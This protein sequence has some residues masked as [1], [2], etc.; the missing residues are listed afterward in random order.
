MAARGHGSRCARILLAFLLAPVLPAARYSSTAFRRRA[1]VHHG[2]LDR[3]EFPSRANRKNSVARTAEAAPDL[4]NCCFEGLHGSS[5]V[6]CHRLVPDLPG[7]ERHQPAQQPAGNLDPVSCH[8]CRQLLFR[9]AFW[10]A[11]QT[12]MVSRRCAQGIHCRR[13]HWGATAHPH[14]LHRQCLPHHRALR[15][16]DV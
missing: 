16:F 5:L 7:C 1:A 6:L 12:W 8:G 10:R 14:H 4:G 2:S 3:C 11:H 13:G 15:A 9:V